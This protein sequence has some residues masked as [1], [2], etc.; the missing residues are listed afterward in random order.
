MVER[1]SKCPRCHFWLPLPHLTDLA[2]GIRLFF[3]QDAY[4]KRLNKTGRRIRSNILSI[5]FV[6]EDPTQLIGSN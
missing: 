1:R 2:D 3:H 6:D 5:D 4:Q